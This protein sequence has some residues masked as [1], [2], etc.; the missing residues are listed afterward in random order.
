M[1]GCLDINDDL[2]DREGGEGE[3]PG[4][5]CLPQETEPEVERCYGRHCIRELTLRLQARYQPHRIL[6]VDARQI[7]RAEPVRRQ[8]LHVVCGGAVREVGAEDDLTPGQA[9]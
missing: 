4:H 2:G 3:V 6:S 8:S 1:V 9:W 7:T 5:D